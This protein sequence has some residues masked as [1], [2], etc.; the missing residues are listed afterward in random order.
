MRKKNDK[1]SS[2]SDGLRNC[3]VLGAVQSEKQIILVAHSSSEGVL[4]TTLG[5]QNLLEFIFYP[6]G[7]SRDRKNNGKRI[8]RKIRY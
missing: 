2:F 4:F 5:D 6:R 3:Y 7:Y 1:C 8:F